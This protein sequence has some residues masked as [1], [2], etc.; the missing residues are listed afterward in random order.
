MNHF[1]EVVGIVQDLGW[2]LYFC[3]SK[4]TTI[5]LKNVQFFHIHLKSHFMTIHQAIFQSPHLLKRSN[6][7]LQMIDVS[8][9]NMNQ[10]LSFPLVIPFGCII[11]PS[12]CCKN[13]LYLP[14][15][16]SSRLNLFSIGKL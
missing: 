6:S 9:Q 15:I 1:M 10:I 4:Y 7:S 11:D 2:F 14:S 13:G 3:I 5:F 16:N 8:L 12:P